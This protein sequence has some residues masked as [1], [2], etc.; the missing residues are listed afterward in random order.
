MWERWKRIKGF[1]EISDEEFRVVGHRCVCVGEKGREDECM[2]CLLRMKFQASLKKKSWT[3]FLWSL[4]TFH[5]AQ[6]GGS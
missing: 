5:C 4:A 6:L 3:S 2:P 1:G